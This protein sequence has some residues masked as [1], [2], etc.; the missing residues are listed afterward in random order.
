MFGQFIVNSARPAPLSSAICSRPIALVDRGF[1][2]KWP[3]EKAIPVIASADWVRGDPIKINW[4][5]F[6][7]LQMTNF[8]WQN[9][10]C[11][12]AQI[13]RR[14]S[15]GETAQKINDA[16][17]FATAVWMKLRLAP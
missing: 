10:G 4:D 15:Y 16:F 12:L 17:D 1:C 6:A 9:L 11:R 2:P 8:N 13:K 14:Q 7:S 5:Y 3:L